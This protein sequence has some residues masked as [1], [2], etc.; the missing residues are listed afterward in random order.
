MRGRFIGQEIDLAIAPVGVGHAVLPRDCAGVLRRDHIEHVGLDAFEVQFGGER[1][2]IDVDQS[3]VGAVFDIAFV[4]AVPRCH[5]QVLFRL[6]FLVGVEDEHP[7]FRLTVLKVECDL[8]RALVR[9]RRTAVRRPGHVNRE[10][11]AVGHRLELPAQRDGLWPGFPGMQHLGLRLGVIERRDFAPDEIDAGRQDQPVVRKGRP[12][13]ELEGARDRVDGRRIVADATHSPLVEPV[14]GNG[15]IADWPAAADH[16][17]RQRA[18]DELAAA[19]DQRDVDLAIAPHAHIFGRR[20]TAI[21]AA[22][23]DDFRAAR[24]DTRAAQRRRGKRR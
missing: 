15:D 21:T 22:D 23:N 20:R 7:G 5:E 10:Q 8:T 24:R 18:R 12:A 19:F 9:R 4:A 14:V 17:V 13:S 11:A 6:H 1:R 3:A 16:Q 2:H